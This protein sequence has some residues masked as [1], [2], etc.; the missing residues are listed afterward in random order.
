[1]FRAVTYGIRR[2]AASWKVVLERVAA[3]EAALLDV[4]RVGGGVVFGPVPGDGAGL[5]IVAVNLKR[6]I[7]GGHRHRK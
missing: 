2:N 3:A 5:A 6:A 1:M 7:A 4:D